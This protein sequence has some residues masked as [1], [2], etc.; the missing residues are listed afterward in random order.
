MK[1]KDEIQ[2]Y[3]LRYKVF[4]NFFMEDE[5][6]SI[7]MGA[8]NAIA[9]NAYNSKSLKELKGINKEMNSF[10][11]ELPTEDKDKLR[12]R[13]KLEIGEDIEEEKRLRS[14]AR[15]KKNGMI[16]N[17]KEY[18]LIL[19]EVERIYQDNNLK[20]EVDYLNNLLASFTLAHRRV[21][22]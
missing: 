12:L 10:M 16:K 15:V 22:E 1:E 6:N 2:Y 18:E 20:H 21:S 8:F 9:V 11:N 17:K 5:A 13:L 7:A 4:Y 3:W 14:I 19:N